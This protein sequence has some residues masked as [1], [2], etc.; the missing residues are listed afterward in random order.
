VLWHEGG[1]NA[2]EHHFCPGIKSLVVFYGLMDRFP[3]IREEAG[4]VDPVWGLGC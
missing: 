1:V 2:T 4:D 3:G